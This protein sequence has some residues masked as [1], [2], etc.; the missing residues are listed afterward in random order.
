ML[1]ENMIKE[2][3]SKRSYTSVTSG[4]AELI[5]DPKKTK[6]VNKENI[7][8]DGSLCADSDKRTVSIPLPNHDACVKGRERGHELRLEI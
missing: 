2:K 5:S 4:L 1:F 3:T 7:T 8:R 6:K